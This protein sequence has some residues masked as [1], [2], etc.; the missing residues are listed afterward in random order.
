MIY[1]LALS[2]DVDRDLVEDLYASRAKFSAHGQALMA[3]LLMQIR[4]SRAQ[5][6]VKLLEAGAHRKAPLFGGNLNARKCS[7]FLP[8]IHLRPPLMRS[9]PWQPRPQE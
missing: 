6:F 4:D 2:G 9:K 7:T 1:A 5:E 3:L 8:T